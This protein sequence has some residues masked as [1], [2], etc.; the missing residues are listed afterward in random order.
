MA[1]FAMLWAVFFNFCFLFLFFIIMNTNIEELITQKNVSGIV[2]C[3]K[4]GKKFY[5]WNI[6]DILLSFGPDDV[7][8]IMLPI[9]AHDCTALRDHI[10]MECISSLPEDISYEIFLNHVRHGGIFL[11]SMSEIICQKFSQDHAR[12]IMLSM[13]KKSPYRGAL[14]LSPIVKSVVPELCSN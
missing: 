2:R 4:S 7:K 1:E 14:Q 5:S 13:E 10:V 12:D 11:L 9:I 3:A 8:K 6:E